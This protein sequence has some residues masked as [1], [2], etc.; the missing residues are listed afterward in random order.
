M[1]AYFPRSRQYRNSSTGVLSVAELPG[2]FKDLPSLSE[3]RNYLYGW[4]TGYFAADG[5]I[6]NTTAALHCADGEVMERI[7]A[8]CTTVGIGTYGIARYD[9]TGINGVV[10]PMYRLRLMRCDLTPEFFVLPHHRARFEGHRPEY[11]RRHWVVAAV[12]QT[13]RVDEVFCAT[14]PDSHAFALK[15]N[16]LTG[17]CH[18][19]GAGAT[20]YDLASALL[21]GPTGP[22]LRS[23]AFKRAR[24]YV[25][26][27]L[28]EVKR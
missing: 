28:G 2:Y 18:A 25:L 15:D 5:D 19:C 12:E 7:Q 17:N 16:I 8:I 20:I 4:L 26:E 6:T 24:A 11:E 23:E 22:E 13:D 27:V 3:A 1:L 10:S 9:R 21:G 14:V